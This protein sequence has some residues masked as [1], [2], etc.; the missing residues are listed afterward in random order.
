MPG[1]RV[2]P[3]PASSLA[4]DLTCRASRVG[5]ST[6]WRGAGP[7]RAPSTSRH[8]RR[9]SPAALRA[10]ASPQSGEAPERTAALAARRTYGS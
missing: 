7:A 4:P 5:L 3:R 6:K 1:R 2:S 10:S 8:L 9:T